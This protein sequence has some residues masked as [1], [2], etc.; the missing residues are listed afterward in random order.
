MSFLNTLTFKGDFLYYI[1]IDTD[2]P[3]KELFKDFIKEYP[4][5]ILVTKGVDFE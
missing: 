5:C 2:N 1:C 4:K 3:E